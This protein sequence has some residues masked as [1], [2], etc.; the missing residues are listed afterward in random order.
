MWFMFHWVLFVLMA[1]GWARSVDRKDHAMAF[2][3][4]LAAVLNLLACWNS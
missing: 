1:M 4:G 2:L 3:C